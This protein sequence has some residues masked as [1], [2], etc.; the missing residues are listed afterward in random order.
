MQ[1]ISMMP[2]GLEKSMSEQ[3]FV[4]L[5]AFLL[6]RDAPPEGGAR[7]GAAGEGGK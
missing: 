4:D 2:E 5:V 1:N 6:T 3:E 7:G